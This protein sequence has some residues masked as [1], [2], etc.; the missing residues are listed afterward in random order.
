MKVILF[1]PY[2]RLDDTELFNK[3]YETY[4]RIKRNDMKNVD[5]SQCD[6]LIREAKCRKLRC[7]KVMMFKRMFF[8]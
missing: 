4:G 2:K 8:Q 7:S 6:A 1:R 5:I 3:I